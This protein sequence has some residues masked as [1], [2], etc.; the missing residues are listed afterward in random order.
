MLLD[1][2]K[3]DNF[4]LLGSDGRGRHY[5]HRDT[6]ANMLKNEGFSID[7]MERLH[8]RYAREEVEAFNLIISHV[9]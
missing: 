3:G 6:I 2:K 4:I 8:Q 9:E 1:E 7:K 5:R